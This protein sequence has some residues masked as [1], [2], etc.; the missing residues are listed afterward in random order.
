MNDERVR[1]RL[2]LNPS[3]YEN[4]VETADVLGLDKTA[5]AT[6]AFS[7]GLR[8]LRMIAQP[9]NVQS[10]LRAE[11]RID[12]LAEEQNQLALADAGLPSR[13]Q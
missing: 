3:L 6:F 12:E 9:G 8:A 13:R 7:L 11:M 4:L 2:S 10:Q 1:L 5:L